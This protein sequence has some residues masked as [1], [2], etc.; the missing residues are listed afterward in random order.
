MDGW[1]RWLSNSDNNV[2]ASVLL[3]ACTY[4]LCNTIVD[5]KQ[6]VGSHQGEDI[7]LQNLEADGVIEL[8][9]PTGREKV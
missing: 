2:R 3:R 5:R 4:G 8:R 7:T 9:W 1:E 6:V